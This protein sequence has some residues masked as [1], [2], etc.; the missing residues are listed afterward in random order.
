MFSV[1]NYA[2]PSIQEGPDGQLFYN[3]DASPEDREAMRFDRPEDAQYFAEEN[4]KRVSPLF[5][6]NLD[7]EQDGGEYEELDLTDE[8]IEEYRRGGHVVEELPKAQF[9]GK[10]KLRTKPSNVSGYTNIRY[11]ITT[12]VPF[13][14]FTSSYK[15]RSIDWGHALR[16]VPQGP[17]R[18]MPLIDKV[19][20]EGINHTLRLA[21]EIRKLQSTLPSIKLNNEYDLGQFKK[22]YLQN[23]GLKQ[24]D[25]KL[26]DDYVLDNNLFGEIQP[27]DLANSIHNDLTLPV[28]VQKLYERNS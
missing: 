23:K 19:Q 6:H 4:Y 8:E 10:F 15:P 13:K 22:K 27:I 25:F 7:E 17:Y 16:E 1:D 11:P 5:R 20:R 28:T 14:P 12:T 3:T 24:E 9:G 18:S 26:L 2:V 21:D